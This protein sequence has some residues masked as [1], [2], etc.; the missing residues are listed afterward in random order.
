MAMESLE[1]RP[2]G[3]SRFVWIAIAAVWAGA[4]GL[5]F[6]AAGHQAPAQ[7]VDEPF[8]SARQVMVA[9]TVFAFLRTRGVSPAGA[10]GVLGNFEQ[11][12]SLDPGARESAEAGSGLGLAQWSGSRRGDFEAAARAEG[13]AWQNLDFQ[14]DF[15]IRELAADYP[16]LWRDLMTA[17]DPVAAA[18]QFHDEFE[19]SADT[20]QA[21]R[22]VR[23]EAAERWLARLRPPANA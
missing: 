7:E 23:G 11:E 18:V 12:S 2:V 20:P 10:A 13:V 21:V 8:V 16:Q 3:P 9:E 4:F 22:G 19:R 17:T 6:V 5:G 15:L 14:L 1:P